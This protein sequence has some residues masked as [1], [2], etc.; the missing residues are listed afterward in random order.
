MRNFVMRKG[1]CRFPEVS[2]ALFL[3]S[4]CGGSSRVNPMP[5]PNPLGNPRSILIRV[6]V[7]TDVAALAR[8]YGCTVEDSAPEDNLYRF[9]IPSD[10]NDDTFSEHLRGDSRFADAETD[11]G[12]RAPEQGTVTGDPIHVPFDFVGPS[13]SGFTAMDSAYDSGA[14]I[15]LGAGEQVGLS[16][17]RGVR[18]ATAVTVAVLDTGVQLDHPNLSARLV[19]GYNAITPG[20]TPSDIADG[21]TNQA[22]GHGTMVAGIVA[23]VAPEAKILPIRVLNA[24]GTGSVFNVVRGLRWAVSQGAQVVNVSFGTTKSSRALEE[25]VQQARRAGVLVVA[26]AGNAGQARKDYPAAFSDALAVAATDASD[27]KA[28]FSNYG[29]HIGLSAPGTNIV[30]TFVKGGFATWSGTSFAAPFVSGAAARLR[31]AN[32]TL[33]ADKIAERLR[34]SARSIDSV[35][36]AYSGKLGK[37]MLDINA[38]LLGAKK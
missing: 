3:L 28:S 12:V 17:T 14:V 24:D 30:S 29:S 1:F 22:L 27:R 21:T 4:G 7:G 8:E 31:A 11:E 13:D 16:L 38:A 19:P 33:S 25:A 2:V 23:Q 37:G 6:P 32:P 9:R 20:A 35:N 26:S 10:Q 15:T 34:D 18:R 5:T 36:P